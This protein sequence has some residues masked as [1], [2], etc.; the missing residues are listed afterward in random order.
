MPLTPSVVLS[1][2]PQPFH[3]N[4]PFPGQGISSDGGDENVLTPSTVVAS[5]KGFIHTIPIVTITDTSLESPSPTVNSPSAKFT[6]YKDEMTKRQISNVQASI[7][8]ALTSSSSSSIYNSISDS[9]KVISLLPSSPGTLAQDSMSLV[10]SSTRPTLE[11][12]GRSNSESATSLSKHSAI[13]SLIRESAMPV[14]LVTGTEYSE[15]STGFI[16]LPHATQT[17]SPSPN[18]QSDSCI[19][20]PGYPVGRRSRRLSSGKS[21]FLR[22]QRSLADDTA[23]PSVEEDSAFELSKPK[24]LEEPTVLQHEGKAA[25]A[26]EPSEKNA[27]FNDASSNPSLRDSSY[28][29]SPLMA[30]A[31]SLSSDIKATGSPLFRDFLALDQQ[32]KIGKVKPSTCAFCT[33]SLDSVEAYTAHLQSRKHIGVLE[34]LGMLPAG[35]YEKLQQSELQENH[36]RELEDQDKLKAEIEAETALTELEASALDVVSS[37]SEDMETD[38]QED[39]S[40]IKEET[41][42]LELDTEQAVRTFAEEGLERRSYTFQES[43]DSGMT[44]LASQEKLQRPSHKRKMFHQPASETATLLVSPHLNERL[45]QSLAKRARFGLAH[46]TTQSGES[47]TDLDCPLVIDEP[48]KTSTV[49]TLSS[50]FSSA[51]E[52]SPSAVITSMVVT[53]FAAS[54][55]NETKTYS[56]TSSSLSLSPAVPPSLDASNSLNGQPNTA[57][58]NHP[59]FIGH[60]KSSDITLTGEGE[61]TL[62]DIPGAVTKAASPVHGHSF[63]VA[64]T[65]SSPGGRPLQATASSSAASSGS[66]ASVSYSL[67]LPGVSPIQL[68]VV[69]HAELRP[70]VCEFCDAGFTNDR[71]LRTHLLTH[72]Q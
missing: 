64:S 51:A 65:Q 70:Y 14:L 67:S 2:H 63:S 57:D 68:P 42:D 59:T 29:G 15:E 25:E 56:F 36:R 23:F 30:S 18:S 5:T 52:A 39:D 20:S 26:K 8:T 38:A 10:K 46:S 3:F 35:T 7:S 62:Q 45:R 48:A 17:S 53:S 12:Q 58:H 60:Q 31:V 32:Q 61:G 11:T 9:N 22:R 13:E 34:T 50:V 40:G 43:T 27:D 24:V 6:D 1:G 54:S 21:R 4:I 55:E 44:N 47:E 28:K 66:V 72:G 41:A 71:S 33:E 19:D 37:A 49:S 16:N 69:A